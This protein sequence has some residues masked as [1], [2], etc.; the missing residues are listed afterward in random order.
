MIIKKKLVELRKA[1]PSFCYESSDY[2]IKGNKINI[3]FCFKAGDYSFNPKVSIEVEKEIKVTKKNAIA[4][5][6]LVFHL[7]M[8]ELLSYWKAFCSPKIVI[9]AGYLNSKQLEWW[10]DLLLEGMGQYFFENK[11]DFTKEGFVE[12]VCEKE[13]VDVP[14]FEVKNPKG[15]LLP[16]GGGKDS[17][18]SIEI[19][20]KT[21]EKVT[22]FVLNMNKNI[23]SMIKAAG[24]SNPIICTRKIE[25]SLLELNREGYLNGHTPFVA[26][27]SFLGLI[28]AAISNMKYL[29]LSNEKS[30]NEGNTSFKGK[31]INHQ[32]SKTYA[33][34][35][36]FRSYVS[37]YLTSDVSY[38]SLLRPLYELQIARIFSKY[39]Q[40]F[41]VF[42]SCN[43]AQK[44]YS[45]TKEKI[46]KWCGCCS[47]CLFVFI[48][49]SPFLN[50][51]EMKSIFSK[52]LF[53]D[54]NLI[55]I[56]VELVDDKKVK[57]LE[58]V[59]TRKE[60][61][62]A[63]YLSWKT[64]NLLE[65]KQPELLAYFEKKILPQYTNLEKETDKVL[66]NWDK[67]NFVPVE[68][69]DYFI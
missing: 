51:R 55:P 66:N 53:D 27:L 8:V 47:K 18:T 40:Y 37:K 28:S 36:A 35:K 56:M 14:C 52:D 23:K 39:P 19:C 61:L 26:Y 21:K 15:V 11:I 30:S 57:P 34:E 2:L 59:G 69:K 67:N 17:A 4:L 12:F 3:S 50:K 6:N 7:G 43:E 13:E 68:W 49:L 33:F 63:L 29:V 62:I 31:E 5:D 38:F 46:E 41:P 16:I 1:Y 58:C 54:K 42:L 45:G 25:D 22:P 64:N 20:K 32:Y 10:K 44:T 65:Q 60:C 24:L 48:V 9:Q